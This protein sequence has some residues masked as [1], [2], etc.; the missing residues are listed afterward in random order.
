MHGVISEIKDKIDLVEL[1]KTN[2]KEQLKTMEQLIDSRI[3]SLC[4]KKISELFN[5]FHLVSTKYL[6]K[7]K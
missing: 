5:L 6:C 7:S 3:C 4:I 2:S 1:N